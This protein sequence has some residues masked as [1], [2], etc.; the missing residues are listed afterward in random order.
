MGFQS[1][2]GLNKLE[3]IDPDNIAMPGFFND[4]NLDQIVT[5]IFE[6]QK[7]YNLQR[8]YYYSPKKE[9]INYRLE[10]LEDFK[11]ERV[12]QSI[13]EFSLGMRRTRKCMDNIPEAELAAQSQKW[14]LDSAMK[15]IE[16]VSTLYQK[17][18][19]EEIHSRGLLEFRTWLGTYLSNESFQKLKECSVELA[20]LFK[21]MS[22]TFCIK[23]DR[24][25]IKEGSQ[26]EDYCRELLD[27]LNHKDKE[28]SY[29]DN[30][31]ISI[32]SSE[33]EK[34]ILLTLKKTYKSTFM[35]LSEY[36]SK[37]DHFID[38][39]I[40]D[41]EQEIQF[42]IAFIK[43]QKKMADM[44]FHFCS[45]EVGDKFAITQLYDL[46]L[47]KANANKEKKIVFN[48][49]YFNEGEKFFV[50]TGPNQGGKTTYARA[51]GQV[52]YFASMGLFVPAK[53]AKLPAFD[54]IFTHFAAE[55]KID[56][57]AGKLKEELFRLKTM[58]D[59]ATNHSFVIINEIFTSATSYDGYIMGKRV[60][61]YF[62]DRE[63]LGVYVTHI[64]ELTKDGRVVSLV[65][66]M[67]S[68]DSNIRTFKIERR[69]SDGRSYANSIVEK[70]HMSYDEIKE[71]IKQ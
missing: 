40:V 61:D 17:L 31:F 28:Q 42:Y 47:A 50:I 53:S 62:I 10:V 4:L 27:T 70:Y 52:L 60:L 39:T 22:F 67:L 24:I 68:Q 8:Y 13:E 1:I 57:G 23:R 19:Q 2:L 6:E 11:K 43:Y 49:A 58:M 36:D 56:S 46:A 25:I 41:F 21:K 55:E 44:D 14:K 38:S 64:S 65:A 34:T 54:G 26:E 33:L 69:P 63:C 35:K 5:D 3:Y 51:L 12:F 32:V 16:C 71:R 48:D 30:P 7:L 37:Y 29:L 18:S 15:Y 45:P 66:S 59:K 20:E 9:D